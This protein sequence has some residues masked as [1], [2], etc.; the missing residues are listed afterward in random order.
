A[1]PVAGSSQPSTPT[2]AASQIPLALP[3]QPIS[4]A[5]IQ[6]VR[7]VKS[8]SSILEMDVE[9]DKVRLRDGKWVS[10]VLPGTVE[11]D[12]PDPVPQHQLPPPPPPPHSYPEQYGGPPG[13]EGEFYPPP[14]QGQGMHMGGMGPPPGMEGYHHMPPP[15]PPHHLHGGPPPAPPGHP[16]HEFMP[17]GMMGPPQHMHWGGYE[18]QGQ[19]QQGGQVQQGQGNGQQ[20]EDEEVVFVL[21][22]DGESRDGRS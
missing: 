3:A 10:F 11:S 21:G 16:G 1:I 2:L 6:L 15:P 13:Y 9:H 20:E 18:G 17:M 22:M 8:L 5:S 4:E 7:D 19:G 12:V 14:Q